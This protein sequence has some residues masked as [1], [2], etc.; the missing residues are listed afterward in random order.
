M[1]SGKNSAAPNFN[2][3]MIGSSVGSSWSSSSSSS[4]T[5]GAQMSDPFGDLMK[6]SGN[7]SASTSDPFASMAAPKE[8]KPSFGIQKRS[9]KDRKKRTI[10]KTPELGSQPAPSGS[11]GDTL[12][13]DMLSLLGGPSEPQVAS[14]A[15][16]KHI[17]KPPTSPT[18][19]LMSMFGSSSGGTRGKTETTTSA[20]NVSSD[21]DPFGMLAP[22]SSAQAEKNVTQAQPP[23]RPARKTKPQASRPTVHNKNL[24][25]NKPK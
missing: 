4:G 3:G 7:S 24:N 14:M 20:A 19:D 18:S 16:S 15:P 2:L 10:H 12:G 22:S 23:L 8:T 17:S 6:G 21:S 1:M 13:A 9:K 5:T 11:A 25:D